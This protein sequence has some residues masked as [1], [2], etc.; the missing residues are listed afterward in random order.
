MWA[1]A[2][3]DLGCDYLI[4]DCLRPVLDAL[5]LIENNEAGRHW[6]SSKLNVETRPRRGSA[7]YSTTH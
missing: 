3:R 6:S 5:G 1:K 2:L 4:L 7:G